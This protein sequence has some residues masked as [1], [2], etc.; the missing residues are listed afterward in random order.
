MK[1]SL[2]TLFE[3]AARSTK[4]RENPTTDDVIYLLKRMGYEIKD[5][6]FIHKHY[7]AIYYAFTHRVGALDFT[8]GVEGKAS[9]AVD[10][11]LVKWVTDFLRAELARGRLPVEAIEE[12]DIAGGKLT[13]T[14]QGKTRTYR[15]GKFL[16]QA[17]ASD[18]MVHEFETRQVDLT[19]RITADPVEVASMSYGRAWTSCMRPGHEYEA[20]PISDVLAGSALVLFYRPGSKKP[21]GRVVLRPSAAADGVPVIVLACR[22]YGT[23]AELDEEDL[24]VVIREKTGRVVA[25]ERRELDTDDG[26]YYGVYDDCSRKETDVDLEDVPELTENL[27]QTWLEYGAL[28]EPYDTGLTEPEGPDEDARLDEARQ[29]ATWF[30]S[31][32]YRN[33]EAEAVYIPTEGSLG[34]EVEEQGFP[35]P[36][37]IQAA[38]DVI[39][40]SV[41]TMLI[42]ASEDFTPPAGSEPYEPFYPEYW[43]REFP[44]ITRAFEKH[45]D[46]DEVFVWEIAIPNEAEALQLGEYL[47]S[48]PEVYY[49]AI[50]YIV[51]G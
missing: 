3:V 46:D 26:P 4:N 49:W 31:E 2:S 28:T 24:E 17:G 35:R 1:V 5:S 20:G 40:S 11:D 47:D 21:C 25:V 22:G 9:N 43:R 33:N 36:V 37:A 38:A 51:P 34:H 44:G 23:Y 10:E 29:V 6:D 16:K 42:I 8:T 32:W 13:G 50:I 12:L 45:A 14:K 39:A 48:D 15:L 19:W 18:E 27:R 30:L 7:A 41:H